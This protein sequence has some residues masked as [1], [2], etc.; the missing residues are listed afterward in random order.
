MINPT[1]HSISSLITVLD[2]LLLDA[3][4]ATCLAR[5]AI[6]EGARNRA[7]GTLLPAAEKL[8]AANSV[9]STIFTLHRSSHTLENSNGQ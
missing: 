3:S 4:H 8:D 9:L 7:I 2:D 5:E 1:T 6:A